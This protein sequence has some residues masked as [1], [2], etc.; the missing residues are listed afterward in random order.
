MNYNPNTFQ[1]P[2]TPTTRPTVRLKKK[3]DEKEEMD[4]IRE[5]EG[6]KKFFFF[7]KIEINW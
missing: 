4:R 1:L 2:N 7:F 5:Q 6:K 3:W